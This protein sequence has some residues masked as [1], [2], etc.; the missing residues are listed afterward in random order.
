LLNRWALSLARTPLYRWLYPDSLARQALGVTGSYDETF[1]E[2]LILIRQPTLLVW[3]R[4]DEKVPFAYADAYREHIP[5]AELR[6]APADA[7][8]AVG[9]HSP[10][11][12]AQVVCDFVS[13]LPA[14][15]PPIEP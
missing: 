3:S 1:A 13:R 11:W 10:E 12:T 9:I 2:A 15:S 5:Q 6:E 7:G 14:V 8:H 4:S